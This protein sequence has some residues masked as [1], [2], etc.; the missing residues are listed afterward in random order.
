MWML[1]YYKSGPMDKNGLFNL[2][3]QA[4]HARAIINKAKIV[5]LEV[6]QNMPRALGGYNEVVHIS[7]VDYVVEGDN[8]PLP[9]IPAA[10]PTDSDRKIAQYVLEVIAQGSCILMDIGCHALRSRFLVA[11]PLG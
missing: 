2:G 4:S 10:V 1:V 9:Q 6:N 5:I 8:P 11:H 7:E 3:I